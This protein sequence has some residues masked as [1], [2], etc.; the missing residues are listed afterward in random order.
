LETTM[1]YAYIYI[2]MW[3]VYINICTI[4]IHCG[5]DSHHG[6]LHDSWTTRLIQFVQ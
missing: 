1:L 6:T 4:F 2:H 3:Y 5:I